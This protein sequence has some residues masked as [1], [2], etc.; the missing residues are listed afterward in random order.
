MPNYNFFTYILTNYNKTVLYIGV[1]NN[2][3][4]RIYEHYFN[5]NKTAF[6]SKYKCY[7]LVWYERHQFIDHAISR[8]TEIKGWTRGKKDSLI[9]L[10]NPEWNFLNTEVIDWPPVK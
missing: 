2:I 10:E 6:T 8:E 4:K 9:A 7:Y 1:T 3:G 5:P